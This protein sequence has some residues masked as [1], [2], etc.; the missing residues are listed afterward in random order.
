MHRFY[1]FILI[2][3]IASSA[4][5]VRAES[6]AKIWNELLLEAIRGDFARPTVHARNLFHVSAAMYD[7]WAIYDTLAEP[8]LMGKTI[9]DFTAPLEPFDLP[10]SVADIE[11]ARNE[12]ISHA[13]YRLLQHRFQF[14]PSESIID[15]EFDNQMF[16]LGY[17]ATN[18]STDYLSGDPAALGNYIAQQYINYG[19]Q[20]GSNEIGQYANTYYEPVNDALAPEYPGNPNI[21]DPNRWQ[22]LTLSLFIDQSGNIIT[23][24]TT[25][26]LSPEWG[27]VEPFALTEDDLNIYSRDGHEYWVYHDPG[28]PPF[29]NFNTNPENTEN[30]R[31]G[32]EMVSVWGSHLDPADGVLMDISPGAQGNYNQFPESFDDY[33]Q[34]YDF[35]EGGD[36]SQGH[37]L[38]P[39]TGMPYVPNLVPRGDYSRVLA[40]FWAD[41]PDSETPPGHWFTILNYVNEHPD[42]VRKFAGQ[43]PE[44]DELEWDIKTYFTL[45]GAMHDCAVS[46]WGI[47]GY[48]DYIRPVSAIRMLADLGQSTNEIA[49]NYHPNGIRL[50]PGYIELVNP[51]DPLQGIG[52]QDIG[53]IKVYTWRGHDYIQDTETDVAGVG[54]ILAENWWPYQRPS[55]V[56]PP[57]AGYVS[58][59]STYSRAAAEVLTFLTG[60]EFFP[61]GMG[62]FYVE[63]NEFLVFEDG[64]SVSFN[65]QWA[66]YRDAS[67]QTSLSRIW[68]GIHPP[69]DDIPGRKIGIEVGKDAFDLAQLYFYGDA[70]GDGY[71]SNVDC[72]DNN[73]NINPDAFEIPN[74][75]TDEDCDGLVLII[76]E[77]GDG[78]NSSEDCDDNNPDINPD[79]DEIIN[80]PIDEDCDGEIIVIDIDNDGFNSSFDCDDFNP[81]AY[82]G[83]TEIPNNEVDEDCDGLVLII[84]VDGDGFNSDEDCADLIYDINPGATEIPNNTVDEDCDGIALIIDVDMDGFNS[85]ED[86]DDNNDTAYPGATEIPNNEVDEDCDGI[87][88]IIDIDMDGYNSDEDCDDGNPDIYPGA[89]EIVNNGVD[90]DC[91]GSD[92]LVSIEEDELNA[93]S[94]YPNPAVDF[95]QVEMKTA[96]AMLSVYDLQGA[97][98]MQSLVIDLSNNRL[99]ISEI[100]AG[101]YLVQFVSEEETVVLPLM[102]V[103]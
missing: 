81:D 22:P 75:N 56:T 52:G 34:F 12:A 8:Y 30:Y 91:D 54:W 32:F 49:D 92:M 74:N 48:Y 37:D 5:S 3:L 93:V 68:G 88:L 83:A 2:L 14:S 70:D 95:I 41:G 90:E 53:K 77:D 40:E 44:L 42:L 28:F 29:I 9:G 16:F 57:F 98:I 33:D 63:Q 36:P 24:D 102:V 76:D 73:S 38:N 78:W 80:N 15:E 7:A 18:T 61:G 89:V 39:V 4:V 6:V 71:A 55:F 1:R 99:D 25:E 50:I 27:L 65:L 17:Y 46:A 43:G 67:D 20:D 59:H 21:D 19:F 60:D 26:A 84:D 35:F 13:A 62:E 100:P 86:C 11:D 10:I 72:N 23:D 85:D 96:D 94:F 45:G 97:L 47:K 103:R 101:K 79:A 82:P 31:W 69:C 64:P 51:G 87:A 66:T 58:G